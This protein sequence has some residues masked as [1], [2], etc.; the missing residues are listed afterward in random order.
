MILSVRQDIPIATLRFN[1]ILAE[2]VYEACRIQMSTDHLKQMA[3][4]ICR[5]LD[6]YPTQESTADVQ[7]EVAPLVKPD[8]Q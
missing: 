7:M 5:T 1:T 4:V 2:A 8:V 3:N 6:F